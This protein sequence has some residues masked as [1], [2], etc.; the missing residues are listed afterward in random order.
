MGEPQSFPQYKLQLGSG[1]W[2]IPCLCIIPDIAY[3]DPWL[4]YRKTISFPSISFRPGLQEGGVHSPHV[5][6][7]IVRAVDLIFHTTKA[8]SLLPKFGKGIKAALG[9]ISIV[10]LRVL[11]YL[12]SGQMGIQHTVPTDHL[13]KS[14]TY[15]QKC[16]VSTLVHT[17]LCFQ[18][19]RQCF[20][21][22][23]CTL[24]ATLNTGRKN[25]MIL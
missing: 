16:S 3:S 24:Y 18:P 7:S 9:R 20:L 4:H 12:W 17:V 14:R 19:C 8:K 11:P 25:Q 2:F 1:K 5:S 6:P 10:S 21:A 22:N 23:L 15:S 13:Q